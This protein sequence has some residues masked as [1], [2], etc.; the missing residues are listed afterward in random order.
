[1]ATRDGERRVREEIEGVLNTFGIPFE[2]VVRRKHAAVEFEINGKHL[3]FTYSGSSDPRARLNA[4]ASLRN[5][6]KISGANVPEEDLAEPLELDFEEIEEEEPVPVSEPVLEALPEQPVEEE[7]PM[8]P[9]PELVTVQR[10]EL[11]APKPALTPFNSG[12]YRSPK[13]LGIELDKELIIPAGNILVIPLNRPNSLIDMTKE[14][15]ETLFAVEAVEEEAPPPAYRPVPPRRAPVRPVRKPQTG[16][17]IAPQLG[18]ILTAMVHAA[19]VNKTQNLSTAMITPFLPAR[20]AK[21]AGARIPTMIQ[22]GWIVRGPLL[23]NGRKSGWFHKVTD[24]GLAAARKAKHEAWKDFP[25]LA[26]WANDI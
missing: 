19:F 1:M 24:K 15:F 17:V 3:L 9:V 8:E 7:K 11:F 22:K 18:R 23:S 5:L 4:R 2:H 10:P 13:V 25:D 21:Q 6:L 26:P 20:D 14:Q 12:V 16:S